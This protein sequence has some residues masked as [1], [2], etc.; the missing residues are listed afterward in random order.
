MTAASPVAL[1]TGGSSGIGRATAL[2]FLDAGYKVVICARR[3][4]LLDEV[5]TIAASDYLRACA[6]DVSQPEEAHRAVGV[7]LGE[8]DRLDALISAHGVI[9]N[10]QTIEHLSPEAW[11][12]VLRVNLMGPIYLTK[13][14]IP[15]LKQTRGN[16]V[17][18]SSVNALQA[19][20]FMSPYGVSKGG[21]VTFTMYAA[22]E[23]AEHG[24]R[25]NCVAPGWVDTPMSA[26]FF[27]EVGAVGKPIDTN[28]LKRP[29]T[30]EEIAALILFLA[31]P[32]GSFL[33]G[34]TFV[35]DGGMVTQMAPLR[36]VQGGVS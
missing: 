13:A 33:T 20:P 4:E 9:G 34:T 7:A 1:V 8:F 17:F 19:E 29:G 6:C 30:P 12:D 21:L 26:P 18:V 5:I 14:A 23:L 36:A 24:I 35:A 3:P 32:T 31:G 15:S 16:V 25:V 28:M 10:F 11:D 22:R 27:E 2:A